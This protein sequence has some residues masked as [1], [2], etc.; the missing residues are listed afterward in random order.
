MDKTIEEYRSK[1]IEE[2]KKL[3][4]E[5][6]DLILTLED[7][8]DLDGV[9]ENTILLK[10]LK[11]II[12]NRTKAGGKPSHKKSRKDI[13]EL[14]KEI[15]ESKNKLNEYTEQK[16]NKKANKEEAKLER[17]E[18]QLVI[19]NAIKEAEENITQYEEQKRRK[20]LSDEKARLERLERQIDILNEIEEAVANMLEIE[21][22]KKEEITRQKEKMR[23]LEEELNILELKNKILEYEKNKNME[24]A[25]KER[26]K[27]KMLENTFESL[28]QM[29][30]EQESE[31]RKESKE[32]KEDPNSELAYLQREN[33]KIFKENTMLQEED[34]TNKTKAQHE[35]KSNEAK[36][37]NPRAL[38]LLILFQELHDKILRMELLKKKMEARAEV[39]KI[40][41]IANK[42]SSIIQFKKQKEFDK[43]NED[44]FISLGESLKSLEGMLKTIPNLISW[45]LNE[46]EDQFKLFNE[47]IN[48]SSEIEQHFEQAVTKVLAMKV[49]VTKDLETTNDIFNYLGQ[50]KDFFKTQIVLKKMKM[51]RYIEE[52]EK[53]LGELKADLSTH[54]ENMEKK[55]KECLLNLKKDDITQ[56]EINENCAFLT[57]SLP[58]FK[59]IRNLNPISNFQN[60]PYELWVNDYEQFYHEFTDTLSYCTDNSKLLLKLNICNRLSKLDEENKKGIN[61]LELYQTYRERMISEKQSEMEYAI[62]NLIPN[63]EF[64]TLK[65]NVLALAGLKSEDLNNPE[66]VNFFNETKSK[67]KQALT[68]EISKIRE[69]IDDRINELMS[70]FQNDTIKKIKE[71]FRQMKKYESAHQNVKDF[72]TFK[73]ETETFESYME[74]CKECFKYVVTNL[75]NVIV[76]GYQ[77]K[78]FSESEQKIVEIFDNLKFEKF[79]D[80]KEL[81]KIQEDFAKKREESLKK[82]LIEL[83]GVTFDEWTYDNII[84]YYPT[85]EDCSKNLNFSIEVQTKYLE[86]S[87]VFFST[88]QEKIYEKLRNAE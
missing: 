59:K 24:N 58:K 34:I 38:K 17:L 84:D 62:Y 54:F 42:I 80:V 60:R 63:H 77:Q 47:Q 85:L 86:V 5:T 43:T 1:N 40:Q 10:A 46:L 70:K 68:T 16:R 74:K 8:G 44:C 87:K 35:I 48:L 14:N 51:N 71:I 78:R 29:K 4:K 82:L 69:K 36:Q 67:I 81:K 55:L 31:E 76:N 50:F 56:E 61:F 20:R 45:D 73:D 57:D 21:K 64:E 53:K 88:L 72:I 33:E 9:A 18:H 23:K 79:Y 3:I 15:Q 22:K 13:S 30:A 41:E 25:E 11:N 19:L 83:D 75:H 37:E 6:E 49:D 26:T 39:V 7:D 32:R 28:E 52:S 27:L 66:I 2:L 12:E 65:T